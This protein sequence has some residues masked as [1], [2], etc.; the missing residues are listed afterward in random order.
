[1]VNFLRILLCKDYILSFYT[2]YVQGPKKSKVNSHGLLYIRKF[3]APGG[4]NIITSDY[5]I[6][7]MVIY[8][9]TIEM[10]TKDSTDRDGDESFLL[11][12]K[13]F[14]I[15]ST[16]IFNLGFPIFTQQTLLNIH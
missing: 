3:T 1:M 13:C 11:P 16:L 8:H 6:I 9:E 2:T 4:T 15:L 7:Q 12:R 14:G 5:M 10:T